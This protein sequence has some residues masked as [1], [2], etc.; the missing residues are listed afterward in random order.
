MKEARYKRAH[1]ADPI[2]MKRQNRQNSTVMETRVVG[3]RRSG[4]E[5]SP[6]ELSGDRDVLTL[7]L[8]GDYTDAQ[9]FKTYYAE[10]LGSMYF[11]K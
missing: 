3:K 1:G 5:R 4:R 11:H 7:V 9:S 8:G 10:H 6:R 2:Y